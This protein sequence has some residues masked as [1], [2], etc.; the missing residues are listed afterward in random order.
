M[1][2][3]YQQKQIMAGTKY[4]MYN[5]TF[6]VKLYQEYEKG[7]NKNAWKLLFCRHYYVPLYHHNHGTHDK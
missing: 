4:S 1:F 5:N 3:K 7:K 6:I 2:A